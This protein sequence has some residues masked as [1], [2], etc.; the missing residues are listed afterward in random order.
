MEQNIFQNYESLPELLS[1]SD[2]VKLGLFENEGTAF[3]ARHRGVSPP[4]VKFG[5]RVLYPKKLLMDFF[6]QRLN[7]GDVPRSK[8]KPEPVAC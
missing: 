1:S 7:K 5:R 3:L 6:C 4:Y 2:L 8:R